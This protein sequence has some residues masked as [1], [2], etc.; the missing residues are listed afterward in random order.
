MSTDDSDLVEI[1]WSQDDTKR[2]VNEAS[3]LPDGQRVVM[4]RFGPMAIGASMLRAAQQVHDLATSTQTPQLPYE[5]EIPGALAFEAT[6]PLICGRE[7]IDR[8]LALPDDHIGRL[9]LAAAQACA[10]MA[11]DATPTSEPV[12]PA[13]VLTDIPAGTIPD[14]ISNAKTVA[15]LGFAWGVALGAFAI[16]AVLGA[17]VYLGD[18]WIDQNCEVAVET[19]KADNIIRANKEHFEQQRAAG[20]PASEIKM[21]PTAASLAR[22]YEKREKAKDQTPWIAAGGVVLGGI[23]LLLLYRYATEGG[24]RRAKLA[25]V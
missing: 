2:L 12:P 15:E 20:V 3:A 23:A 11:R 13:Y 4:S 25:W 22:R 16:A 19:V 5:P 1:M 24:A 14:N 9:P 6:I 10:E 8:A 18:E 7:T 17:V 21:S